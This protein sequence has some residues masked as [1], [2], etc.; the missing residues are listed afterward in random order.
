MPQWVATKIAWQKRLYLVSDV[1]KVNLC[2]AFQQVLDLGIPQPFCWRLA[3]SRIQRCVAVL[4]LRDVLKAVG[5]FH[6]PG[7]KP[8]DISQ[9]SGMGQEDRDSCAACL[10]LTLCYSHS[11]W[12]MHQHS[13]LQ[14]RQL[15]SLSVP[16]LT[17][18]F[19]L[20]NVVTSVK[21]LM[22]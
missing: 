10:H 11:R 14:F 4:V 1:Q 21:P 6:T 19:K 16:Y 5:S 12:K 17:N 15:H 8:D 22:L 13:H 3:S 18:K 2:G 20:E 9:K 7:N